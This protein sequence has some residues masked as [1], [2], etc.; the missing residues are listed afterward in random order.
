[1]KACSSLQRLNS[2][3]LFIILSVGI[4]V[5]AQDDENKGLT[6]IVLTQKGI[7]AYGWGEYKVGGRCLC[8]DNFLD[9]DC[10]VV[11][12]TNRTEKVR[13]KQI[14]DGNRDADTSDNSTYF[15]DVNEREREAPVNLLMAE[16]DL[17][18]MEDIYK[19]IVYTIV[20]KEKNKSYLTECEL[21][22]YDQFERLQWAGKLENKDNLDQMTFKLEKPIFTKSLLLKV[23]SGKSKITEVALFGKN[24]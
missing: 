23:R 21:G 7:K 1:L 12:T 3:A 8:C 5:M 22:Y 16:I 14:V 9:G 15:G 18:K 19:V 10:I 13:I 11:H 4:S 24:D 20:D 17:K 2:T 6:N